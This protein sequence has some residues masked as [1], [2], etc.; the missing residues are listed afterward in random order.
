MH[1]LARVYVCEVMG[2][3]PGCVCAVCG[4]V[5]G[6]GGCEC[7]VYGKCGV[8][9]VCGVYMCGVYVTG[10]GHGMCVVWV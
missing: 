10:C 7:V 8:C 1:M 6:A 3:M 4:G 2:A 5:W 9:V